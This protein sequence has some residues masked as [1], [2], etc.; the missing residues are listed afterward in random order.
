MRSLESQN[1]LLEAEIEA[2][3][4]RHVRPSGLRQLYESQ[5]KDLLRDA[6]RMRAQRVRGRSY[7]MTPTYLDHSLL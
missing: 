4:S 3:K 7:L 2:L 5:L 1:K 6:E